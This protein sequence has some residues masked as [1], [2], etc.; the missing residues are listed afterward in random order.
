MSTPAKRS[1]ACD[2]A[3]QAYSE[4]IL[5]KRNIRKEGQIPMLS[6]EFA[7]GGKKHGGENNMIHEKSGHKGTC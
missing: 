6:L 7:D 1:V 3:N 2:G 5:I 4:M